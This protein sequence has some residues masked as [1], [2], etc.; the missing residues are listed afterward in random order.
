MD[1]Q[2]D[3]ASRSPAPPAGWYAEPG[4]GHQR[5]WDGSSW[6]PYA[7]APFHPSVPA[8]PNDGRTIMIVGYSMAGA[9]LV[10]PIFGVAGMVLG[11]V[12]A[13][14]PRRSGHGAAIICLSVVLGA[15][16]WVFWTSVVL[17][18]GGSA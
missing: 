16:S 9:A 4:S 5:Y 11:I 8:D 13:T 3:T 6:S 14:K 2:S 7:P 17:H 18:S 10:L 12:T 15:V 1:G